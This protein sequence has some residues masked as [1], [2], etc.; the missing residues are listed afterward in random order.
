[1]FII[2]CY[3]CGKE[4]EREQDIKRASC[5]TC[6]E[7]RHRETSKARYLKNKI[8]IKKRVTKAFNKLHK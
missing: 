7:K 6:K 3:Y 4:L 1:M 5:F 8:D 2:E